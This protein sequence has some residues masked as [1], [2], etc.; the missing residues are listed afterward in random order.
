MTKQDYS[1]PVSIAEKWMAIVVLLVGTFVSAACFLLAVGVAIVGIADA[2]V[3]PL[4][5]CIAILGSLTGICSCVLIRLLRRQRAANGR[6]V[7]PEWFIQVFGLAF[8]IGICVIAIVDGVPWLWGET[9]GV[10]FAM[11]GIGVY[12]HRPLPE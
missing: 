6:T 4:L 1:V 11:I 5:G 3:G 2:P 12:V 8:L 10:A 7:M 9:V